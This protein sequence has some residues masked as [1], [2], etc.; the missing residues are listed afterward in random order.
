MLPPK[1]LL[2]SSPE[3]FKIVS[4]LL[5]HLLSSVIPQI[6]T[7]EGKQK[8]KI[9]TAIKGGS[10]NEMMKLLTTTI[11]DPLIQSIQPLSHANIL[12]T[13][14]VS[15]KKAKK[16][17]QVQIQEVIDLRMDVLGLVNNVLSI[18]DKL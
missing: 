4:I 18:L 14:N 5:S 10:I 15:G 9:P 1:R 12:E 17:K 11:L 16:D 3:L 13:F 2:P 7:L 6:I 8:S